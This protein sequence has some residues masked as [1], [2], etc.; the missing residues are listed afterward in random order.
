MNKAM[1]TTVLILLS[2]ITLFSVSAFSAKKT[3]REKSTYTVM[4]K[5]LIQIFTPYALAGGYS[6]IK[7]STDY[8]N[9]LYTGGVMV[10]NNMINIIFGSEFNKAYPNLPEDAYA[11]ILCHELGHIFGE[12]PKADQINQL[13]SP[14]A[15]A[16]YFAGAV[17]LK[18]LF[19]AYPM[20]NLQIPDPV[21]GM[22]CLSVYK[23]SEDRKLCER[24][25][26]SGLTFFTALRTS[27]LKT[28]AIIPADTFYAQ[29]D[30]SKKET[31]YFDFYPSLQ[32][33]TETIAAG[34]YCNTSE[35]LWSLGEKNWHCQSGLGARL[36][37]WLKQ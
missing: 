26:M 32:C 11:K 10:E 27:L 37:C 16:D 22:K 14:E 34:A 1:K 5:T 23:K 33:R 8:E 3:I 17:C 25:A 31:R 12:T 13:I 35:N 6:R 2:A 29:P 24:I 9:T 7:I 4:E 21:V 19:R 36:G 30:F 18:K 20:Q 28:K 15:E